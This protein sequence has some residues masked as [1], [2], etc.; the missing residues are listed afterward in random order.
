MLL[1]L[2]REQKHVACQKSDRRTVPS[3]TRKQN[4]ARGVNQASQVTCART[5]SVASRK[6][7]LVSGVLF[8]LL[9]QTEEYFGGCMA[10]IIEFYIPQSFRKVSKW[11]PPSER[12][13]LLEFP[14]AIQQ[15]A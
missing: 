1:L 2:L 7:A 5:G 3:S 10:K 9:R 12:G 15:F 8:L 14:M 4:E 11:L 13:K 6:T